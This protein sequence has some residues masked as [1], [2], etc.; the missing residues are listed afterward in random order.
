MMAAVLTLIAFL[1][2]TGFQLYR[3]NQLFVRE[4]TTIGVY[5]AM[6]FGVLGLVWV[7]M[8]FGENMLHYTLGIVGIIVLILSIYVHGLTEDSFVYPTPGLIDKLMGRKTSFKETENI[9]IEESSNDKIVVKHISHGS[10]KQMAFSR[11]D[12]E[13]IREL[14]YSIET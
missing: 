4:H 13:K 14:L 7:T 12:E 3:I 9:R 5:I 6:I 8:N 2:L 11:D 1:I 10:E